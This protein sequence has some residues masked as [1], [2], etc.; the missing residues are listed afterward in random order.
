M[1][2]HSEIGPLPYPPS[3]EANVAKLAAQIRKEEELE[4]KCKK[5]ADFMYVT[6]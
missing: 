1:N 3:K 2:N 6:S 5:D 4:Q